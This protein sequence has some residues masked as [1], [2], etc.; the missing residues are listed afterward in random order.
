[1]QIQSIPHD[2]CSPSVALRLIAPG[3]IPAAIFP[4]N[5]VSDPHILLCTL[6][7]AAQPAPEIIPHSSFFNFG[8]K[9]NWSGK[10]DP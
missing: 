2:L 3:N 5:C 8:F 10:P 9:Y 4:S 1:M 7:T 6:E